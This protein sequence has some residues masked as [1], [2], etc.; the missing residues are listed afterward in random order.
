MDIQF[1]FYLL[2][3]FFMVLGI[4]LMLSMI[5]LIWQMKNAAM[6]FKQ[7]VNDKMSEVM[8]AR[9]FAGIIP[10]IGMLIKLAAERR[11]KQQES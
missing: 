7:K 9:K 8:Q 5:L 6:E 2:A 10:L 3:S 4:V 11:A 1:I